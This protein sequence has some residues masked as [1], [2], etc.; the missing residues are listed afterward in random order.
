[1]T[2]RAKNKPPPSEANRAGAARQGRLAAALRAN[3]QRRKAQARERM[4]A[5]EEP[6]DKR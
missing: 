3:L 1:M 6:K 5:E 2:D 4:Q